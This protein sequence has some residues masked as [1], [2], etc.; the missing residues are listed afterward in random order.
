[1]AK[2]DGMKHGGKHGKG[3]FLV[4]PAKEDGKSMHGKKLPHHGGHH[5]GGKK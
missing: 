5:H 3:G 2:H 4:S 1:M